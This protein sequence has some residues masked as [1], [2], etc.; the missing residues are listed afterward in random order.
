MS[1]RTLQ[2]KNE[3]KK[4]GHFSLLGDIKWKISKLNT[5][6]NFLI[7]LSLKSNWHQIIFQVPS[8]S[9]L[10]G[11]SI[12]CNFLQEKLDLN[13]YF[14]ENDDLLQQVQILEPKKAYF[15]IFFS[16]LLLHIGYWIP[17]T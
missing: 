8:G 7:F 14:N 13:K 16:D 2:Q 5:N 4:N 1:N 9:L 12:S 11:E 17:L 6:E 3:T 15:D 10:T